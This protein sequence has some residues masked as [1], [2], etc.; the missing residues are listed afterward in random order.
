MR[1]L[2]ILGLLGGGAYLVVKST[3]RSAAASSGVVPASTGNVSGAFLKASN[4][5]SFDD[6]MK[7]AAPPEEKILTYSSKGVSK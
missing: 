2:L 7:S 1:T 5:E 4:S 3:K 6:A